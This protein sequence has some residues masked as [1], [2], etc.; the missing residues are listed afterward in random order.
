[1]FRFT[2]LA[3][4]AAALPL[5][6]LAK[7][8]NSVDGGAPTIH[9]SYADLNLHSSAGQDALS[10]RVRGAARK[11][12]PDRHVRNLKLAMAARA[13]FKTAT[14]SARPQAHFP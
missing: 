7:E 10:R 12:C 4:S 2:L 14:A 13:C 5:A 11:L 9:V 1:M 8:R 3:I 6:A